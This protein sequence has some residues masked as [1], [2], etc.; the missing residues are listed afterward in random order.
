M[1]MNVH[2]KYRIARTLQCCIYAV[3]AVAMFLAVIHFMS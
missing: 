2:I 1:L 3:F